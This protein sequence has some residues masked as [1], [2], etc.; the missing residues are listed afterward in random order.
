MTK[1]LKRIKTGIIIGIFIVSIFAAFTSNASAGFINVKPIINVRHDRAEENVIPKSG[2]LEIDLKTTFTLTGVGATFVQSASS[3]LLKNS[4]VTI[5]LQVENNHDWVDASITNQPAKL[6][7]NEPGTE[8]SSS[9]QLTV[10]E[11]APAFTLGKV[12][13]VATL[14]ELSGILFNIEEKTEVFEVPFE[15][16]YWPV[17]KYELP[18]G[19]FKET[20]PL[21]TV[22]FPVKLKNLGNGV[23][24]VK[25]E[26]INFPGEEWTVSV[27]SSI[28]LKSD[29]LVGEQNTE[30]TIHVTV[31][32]PYGF[33]FHNDRTNFKVKFTPIYLGSNESALTGDTEI[34]TF[35]VQSVGMSPG[36]GFEVP[37][38]V[39]V[40]VALFAGIGIYFYKFRKK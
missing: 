24:H 17:I 4:A 28:T 3:S 16:G 7:I 37:L 40:L 23:T 26:P 38:I 34:I 9:L 25:I 18:E 15:V 30:A 19:N 20:G 36:A 1:S 6:K 2:V 22:D 31:K 29:D 11:K 12:R 10:T 33:G 14:S 21:D 27:P 5:S 32:P 35:N 13:I 39:T 8:W